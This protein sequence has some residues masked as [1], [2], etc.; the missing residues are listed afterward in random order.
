MPPVE[1]K[2]LGPLEVAVDGRPVELRRKKQRALLA[3]LALRAGAVISTDKL[4]DDLWGEAPPKAAVGSLQNLVSELRKL[5]G[6]ELVVTRA[7]GYVLELDRQLVDVHRFER[8]VREGSGLEEALALWRG[9]ALADLSF[10]P[11]AQAEIAR[12]EE[13]RTTAREQLFDTELAEGRHARLVAELEGFVADHPLRERPRGQLML[14]LYRS[15]RQADALDAYRQ[16]RVT[17]VEELGIDPSSELQQLEQAILRHDPALR[18]DG[19]GPAAEP[20][21]RRTVTV[22]FADVVDSTE[23]GAQLDPEVL[24]IVMR[25]YFDAV[26]TAVD[27]HGGVVEKFIGDAAMAVFGVPTLH[28]DDALRAVRGAS[29]LGGAIAGLNADLG[30][31]YGIALQLRMGLNSGEVLVSDSGAGEAFATGNAVNVAMRLEQAAL[32]GEILLG[33]ATYALV[34]HAVEAEGVEPIDLGGALGRVAAFRLDD[35]GEAVR[36]LGHASL[37]GRVDE[38]AWLRAAFAGVCA[39]RRSRV[40]TVLGEAGVG[41]TRLV[42]ELLSGLGAQAEALVG[43]CVSYGDGA[44]F[45]PL[46]E[47]VRQA[48]PSRPRQT[49]ASLLPQDE[50]ASLVAERVTRLRSHA[51]GV[52]S[53]GE[54]FWAVRR[55]LEALAQRLPRVVVLE[56]VHWAEPTL[57]DLVEYLD[58]WT[59]EAPLLVVCVARPELLEQRPG[60]ATP[61]K[62]LSVDPLEPDAADALV[63]ELG[64]DE[65][66]DAARTKIVDVAEGNPLFLEQLLSFA[67]EAGA[68]ALAT[69]PPTVEALLAGRIDRLEPEERAVLERAA[70]AGREFERAAVVHLSPPDEVVGISR[71]LSTLVR[72]GLV[73]HTD[74]GLR[75][76]HVLIRDVAYAAV[77]K[78]TRADLHERFGS[79]LEQREEGAEEIVGYHLEQAHRFRAELR[80]G[81]ESLPALAQ[82]AGDRLAAAGIRAWKGADAPAAANLLA[83]GAVL[84]TDLSERAE[85]LCEL[86]VAQRSTDLAQAGETLNAAATCAHEVRERR[87]ELRAQIELVHLRLFTDPDAD[88]QQLLELAHEAAPVFEEFGDERALA[89]VWRHVGYVRGSLQGSCA[90]W[91]DAAERSLAFYRRTGWSPAGCL[92]ELSVALLQ[93]PTP[94]S[95]AITRCEQLLEEATDRLSTAGV[96]VYLAGM[97]AHGERFDEALALLD[98]ADATLDDLG[99]TWLKACNSGRVRGRIYLLAGDVDRAESSLRDTCTILE[100]LRDASALATVAADL[101]RALSL[102]RSF[103]EASAWCRVARERAP[104]GDKVAQ[105][106]WRRL[107]AVLLVEEERLGPAEEH[108]HEALRLIEATDVLV[109]RGDVLLDFAA[110]LSAAGRYPEAA[111]RLEAALDLYRQKEATASAR[112]AQARLAQLA[113]A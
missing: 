41:K 49:I 57:L 65:V 17:L 47:V 106:D 100:R 93:G 101:G 70:V 63:V 71:C 60:W 9:A 34:R 88:P 18:F 51:E 14:A 109:H 80:P 20:D 98:E 74:G 82:R 61:D 30:E 87:L 1:V 79:W 32:P 94:L 19:A 69:V 95:A 38:L 102:Q 89:R 108:I 67:D 43:R 64:G 66:A 56:D 23:L 62:T 45:L 39:E 40:V 8:A 81:D 96:L 90:D 6:S 105:V 103:D 72:R 46:V 73:D 29:D 75:F 10:E 111:E 91:V 37:V 44:T 7:P 16:A 77:T 113:V 78:A 112:T 25:R 21:R 3:L 5:L 2:L 68:E 15:G 11:F 104:A 76:H 52:A 59:T 27:R 31:K 36:P 84:L 42:A 35:V 13:L 99:E 22:L 33:E 12:L 58:A 54:V 28:E 4:V 26:R 86:G 107:A 92:L 50:H 24:R 110:V 53:T 48:A 97:Y 55:F 83:R 85:T